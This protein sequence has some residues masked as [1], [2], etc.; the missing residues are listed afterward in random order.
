LERS[1]SMNSATASPVV[2]KEPFGSGRVL[3]YAFGGLAVL[4]S[5]VFLAGGSAGAWALGQRDASGYF[6]SGTHELSTNS[7]A[8]S[9]ESIDVDSDMLG[10][11]GGRFATAR[12]Q[13][14]STQPIF[15]GI[16]RTT[17]VERYLAGVQHD[18]ITDVD[19]EPFKVS[20]HRVEGSSKPPSPASQSFWRVQASG[21]GTQKI[22]WSLEKGDWSAVAMNLDGSRG[23][24][25]DA[26]FG[27]RIS[28]LGWL[29]L[30]LL[31]AGGLMLLS[32]AASIYLGARRPRNV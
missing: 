32:G 18:E 11:V 16:A 13:A 10:W 20:S 28:A 31:G 26:R 1:I 17:D 23:V 9:S 2:V 4:A 14:S 21:P 12:M 29:T 8:L 24:S 30:A 19:A 6:T 27:G 15:I 3:L 5:L 22:T 7:Y 25:V